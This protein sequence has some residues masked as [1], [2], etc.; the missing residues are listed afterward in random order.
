MSSIFLAVVL[1]PVVCSIT[2]LCL[3]GND[4][5]GSLLA[6]NTAR[7]T[8]SAMVTLCFAIPFTVGLSSL[9]DEFTAPPGWHGL[10]WLPYTLAAM[11][12]LGAMRGAVLS[13]RDDG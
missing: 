13:K 9:V 1:L 6:W 2:W 5:A 12:W 7:P 10:M 8:R 11:S 3:R 4:D